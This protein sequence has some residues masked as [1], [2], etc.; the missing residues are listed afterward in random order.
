MTALFINILIEKKTKLELLKITFKD[1]CDAFKECHVYIRGKYAAESLEY[2]KETFKGQLNIYQNLNDRDWIESSLVM[3]SKINARS[4]YLYFEDHRLVDSVGKLKRTIEI[5]DE[6]LLDYMCYTSFRATR[7]SINNLLPIN[8]TINENLII[9]ENSKKIANLLG[10]ISPN[11]YVFAIMS[12]ISLEYLK[13]IL[14]MSNSKYKIHSPKISNLIRIFNRYPN[15]R[16]FIN[17]LNKILKKINARYCLYS[18]SSPFNLE[19]MW[20]EFEEISNTNR[21]YALTNLELLANF[22]D[23][24]GAHGE[25][26]V[27]RGL[28]PFHDAA[29]EISKLNSI[30]RILYIKKEEKFDATYFSQID[31]INSPPVLQV[32]C[33]KGRVK[34]KTPKS[35]ITLYEGEMKSYYSNIGVELVGIEDS[36]LSLTIYDECF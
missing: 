13:S 15:C 11:Y 5:F 7:L 25:S 19:K 3:L 35:V 29:C 12:V 16:R 23:D 30:N 17:S 21:R 18:P 32:R 26:L 6:E 8:T 27:K 9:F 20:F 36:E 22:D 34:V 24:N 28:Y 33:N 31:R 4:I 2:I 1:I 14:I 10:K